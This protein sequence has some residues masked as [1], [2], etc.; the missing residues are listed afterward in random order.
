M[1]QFG[2]RHPCYDSFQWVPKIDWGQLG[3]PTRFGRRCLWK[4]QSEIPSTSPPNT[5]DGF[6]KFMQTT[7]VNHGIETRT[8]IGTGDSEEVVQVPCLDGK[9]KQKATHLGANSIPG[10]RLFW[11]GRKEGREGP[12]SQ[13]CVIW[14][15]GWSFPWHQRSGALNPPNFQICFQ[16]MISISHGNRAKQVGVACC[17]TA[18]REAADTN[19]T[20]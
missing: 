15:G 19:P 13:C 6:A 12:V 10:P 16:G 8:F 9:G 3:L 5:V 14:G 7:K 4:D 2:S 11:R 17:W 1:R 18:L 20:T